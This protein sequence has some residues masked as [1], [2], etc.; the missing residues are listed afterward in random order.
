MCQAKRLIDKGVC[1]KEF[2][3][4]P[5]N[6]ECECDKSWD[7]REN[8]DYS[9]WKRRKRLVD[10][11]IEK[12]TENTDEIKINCKNKRGNKYSSCTV[13]IVLFSIYFTISIGIGTYF[14]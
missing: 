1:N 12:C 5:S 9:N 11:L 13:H 6:C 7:I 8:L 3:W 2:I 14:V 4:N 10:K